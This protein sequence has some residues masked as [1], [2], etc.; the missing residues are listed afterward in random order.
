[1]NDASHGGQSLANTKEASLVCLLL[2]M[3]D[4]TMTT[5]FLLGTTSEGCISTLVREGPREGEH[6]W[7]RLAYSVGLK[8]SY[9]SERQATLSLRSD[10]LNGCCVVAQTMGWIDRLLIHESGMWL[11]YLSVVERR[12]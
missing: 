7:S 6:P 4:Y 12:R 5:H 3:V 9:I 1:M 11:S 8:A 2:V 10:C